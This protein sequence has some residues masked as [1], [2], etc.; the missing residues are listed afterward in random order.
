GGVLL[1]PGRGTPPATG[2]EAT[3]AG[4]R[5]GSA[6]QSGEGAVAVPA[7]N[8]H[9][10]CH[11]SPVSITSPGPY[12]FSGGFLMPAL[13]CP[14]P[15]ELRRCVLGGTETF[16]AERLFRHAQ[17]CPSCRVALDALLRERDSSLGSTPNE[18]APGAPPPDSAHA[19]AGEQQVTRAED[20][21]PP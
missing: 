18:A 13:N 2:R 14:S 20:T 16:E 17:T 5:H 15:E 7:S 19:P 11:A 3:H 1:A 10:L 6:R 21:V 4:P 8:V 12:M 9:L